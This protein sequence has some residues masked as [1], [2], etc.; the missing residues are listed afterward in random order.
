MPGRR[1]D[2]DHRQPFDDGGVTCPCNLD[3]L[4]RFHHRVKTFTG[5]SAVR[6]A[7]DR[8]RWTSP[9]GAVHVDFPDPVPAGVAATVSDQGP[10]PF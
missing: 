8:L 2:L 1:C 4:C 10:P 3:A 7:G 6:V 5:W 9:L